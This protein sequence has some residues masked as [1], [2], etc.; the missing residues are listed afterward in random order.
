MSSLIFSVLGISK[1]SL[2]N[3]CLFPRVLTRRKTSTDN[4]IV[5]QD[6]ALNDLVNLHDL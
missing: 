2:F 6:E 3:I 1:Y 4:P 5:V